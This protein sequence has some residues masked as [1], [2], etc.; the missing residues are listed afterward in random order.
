ME[1]YII[2]KTRIFIVSILLVLLI[3]CESKRQNDIPDKIIIKSLSF[4]LNNKKYSRFSQKEVRIEQ[5]TLTRNITPFKIGSFNVRMIEK[6]NENDTVFSHI[7]SFFFYK[8]SR[9]DTGDIEVE[10]IISPRKQYVKLL[11]TKER[12]NWVCINSEL[13]QY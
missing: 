3:S 11:F 13:W 7:S 12:N 10:F 9:Y 6:L 5:N 8:Y 4:I 2:E 1:E